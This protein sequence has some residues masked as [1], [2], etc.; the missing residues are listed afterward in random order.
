MIY[1]KS[2]VEGRRLSIRAKGN[3]KMHL[4][5]GKDNS[6]AH[7]RNRLKDLLTD[8]ATDAAVQVTC[9]DKFIYWWRLRRSTY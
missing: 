2:Q 4:G 8:I 5:A 3:E 9:S 1:I 6:W 7:K